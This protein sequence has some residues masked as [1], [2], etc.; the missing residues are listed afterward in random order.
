MGKK[1]ATEKPRVVRKIGRHKTR[2]GHEMRLT[3]EIGEYE[4]D[5]VILD[6]WLDANVLPKQTSERMDRPVLQWSVI[7]LRMEN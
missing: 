4:M 2:T 7:Q 5:Q 1:N 6:L 3:A